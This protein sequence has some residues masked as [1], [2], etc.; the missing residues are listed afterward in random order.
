MTW[1]DDPHKMARARAA[2]QAVATAVDLA[3]INTA[4]DYGA[5]TGLLSFHLAEAIGHVIVMDTSPGMLE[6]AR[7]EIA[8][9]GLPWQVQL[10]D[11]S[12][13]DDDSPS[14]VAE[15]LYSMLA[16]HHVE[17]VDAAI[18]GMWRALKPGGHLVLI[19]LPEG[20]QDFHRPEQHRHHDGFPVARL[21]DSLGLAGFERIVW[22]DPL[23]IHHSHPDGAPTRHE[24]FV[25]SA[26][27]P[28]LQ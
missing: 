9:R 27:R 10:R 19:D 26:L 16:L 20:S 13:P 21:E 14:Q 2:A 8:R 7:S 22:S 5:G 1:N 17:D 28:D 3:E 11:L 24:L 18:A 6:V 15:L 12:L 25:V 23:T 4:I